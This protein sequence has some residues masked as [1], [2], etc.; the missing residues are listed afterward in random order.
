M[1]D[2]GSACVQEVETPQDLPAPAAHHLRP[3][4]FQPLHVTV[5]EGGKERGKYSSM[6][7]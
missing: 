3:Q 4:L 5:C 2:R 7:V 6:E 1:D